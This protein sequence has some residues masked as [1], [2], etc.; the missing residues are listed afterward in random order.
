MEVD[1]E[2]ALSNAKGRKT[3]D[4]GNLLSSFVFRPSSFV[5]YLIPLLLALV[6]LWTGYS[7]ATHRRYEAL[8]GIPGEIVAGGSIGQTFVAEYDGLSGVDV[9]L[10]TYGRQADAHRA[11][12]VMHLRADPSSKT[13]IATA[14]LPPSVVLDENGWYHFS[15]P[16][17]DGSRGKA[18]YV[19]VDLPDGSLANGLGLYW[20]KPNPLGDPYPQGVAYLNGKP[21]RSDLTFGLGYAAPPLQVWMGMLGSAAANSSPWA[22][23]ALLVIALAGIVWALVWLP[24]IWRDPERRRWWLA[25]WS[26]P[27][28]LGVALVYGLLFMLLVPPW[29]GPDEYSH[30][31]YAAL[32]DKH[33][34]DSNEVDR[35]NL[36]GKD[37]DKALINSIN[38]SADRHNFTRLFLGSAAP[39]A[40]TDVT[41]YVFQQ[42]RQPATYYWL[43]AVAMRVARALGAPA[44]P[45]TNPEA[46]LMAMRSVSLLLGLVVVALAWSRG[47]S[48]RDDGRWT[49]DDRRPTTDD[50]REFASSS[51][52]N[53]LRLSSFVFRHHK[54]PGWFCSCLSLWLSCRCICSLLPSPTTTSLPR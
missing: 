21:T 11:T 4:E 38:A 39:G 52:A 23:G 43:S 20:Y 3:K 51:T 44:D 2:P 6:V 42:T 14:S 28:V 33:N 41:A 40:P 22:I 36:Y 9:R 34:L 37:Q 1:E 19:Q 13:D 24:R 17:I 12:L 48:C 5:K 29:Q 10:G 25:R 16:A 18:Y 46:A 8:N 26:L 30:F 31:A 54:T 15:F 32:L 53:L 7:S 45:Y 27:F 49:M 47:C 35:L 50:R